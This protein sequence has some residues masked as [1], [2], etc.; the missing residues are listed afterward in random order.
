M[1]A[2]SWV[3]VLYVCVPGVL[4]SAQLLLACTPL[5]GWRLGATAVEGCIARLLGPSCFES[6][7][8][9]VS[10]PVCAGLAL[11][12]IPSRHQR[13]MMTMPRALP[14]K[15][16][17]TIT[18]SRGGLSGGQQQGCRGLRTG[19]AAYSYIHER[20]WCDV[21]LLLRGA[22]TG[23]VGGCELVVCLR[24]IWAMATL[25]VV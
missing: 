22:C 9:D 12:I 6:S 1:A 23:V 16:R 5:S 3:G 21:L 19:T 2:A 4:C 25:L 14:R 13:G 10:R 24:G 11:C 18:H 8:T 17:T 20:V 15:G 7:C